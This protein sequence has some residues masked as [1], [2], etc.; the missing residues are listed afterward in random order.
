MDLLEGVEHEEPA[1]MLGGADEVLVIKA[2]VPKRLEFSLLSR[3]GIFGCLRTVLV[4]GGIF[5]V[6]L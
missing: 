5:L 2:G 6:E 3:F 1:S 4:E